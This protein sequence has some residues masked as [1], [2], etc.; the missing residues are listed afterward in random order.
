MPPEDR[1][2]GHKPGD[3]RSHESWKSRMDTPPQSFWGEHHPTDTWIL[4]FQPQICMGTN[5]CCLEPQLG[6]KLL[7]RP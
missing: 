1:G 7:Q 5:F 2:H 3:V 4:N 6:S